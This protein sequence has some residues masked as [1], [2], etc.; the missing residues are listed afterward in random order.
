VSVNAPLAGGEVIT[1][2]LTFEGGNLALNVETSGAGGVQVE[3]QDADGHPL[4]G[5]T[6]A[7]CPAIFCDRVR[8]VVRWNDRGGDLRALAG[9]QLRLRFVLRDADLYAF[10]FVPYEPDPAPP[11]LSGINLPA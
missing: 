1:K 8:H 10:Q 2:P 11:D 5:H 6:L 3:I 7:D 4:E 9:K